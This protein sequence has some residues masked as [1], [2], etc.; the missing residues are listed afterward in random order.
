M[1]IDYKHTH[2]ELSKVDQK[3]LHFLLQIILVVFLIYNCIDGMWLGI[4]QK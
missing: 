1:G 4:K 3:L 2:A